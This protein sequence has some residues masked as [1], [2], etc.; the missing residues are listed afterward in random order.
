MIFR[1]GTKFYTSTY[2]EGATEMQDEYPYE[3]DGDEV[4]C[5]EVI[6]TPQEVIVYEEV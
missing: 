2:S 5:K 4:E 1:Y 6:P 3:Y